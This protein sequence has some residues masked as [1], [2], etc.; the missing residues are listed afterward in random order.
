[1]HHLFDE[2]LISRLARANVQASVK[3]CACENS[4]Y[5]A[6]TIRIIL[7]VCKL[8]LMGMGMVI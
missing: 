5:F 3:L 4:F 6:K 8:I 7:V 2:F 1:M